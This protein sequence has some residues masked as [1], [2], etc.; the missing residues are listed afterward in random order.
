MIASVA[1]SYSLLF[2]CYLD[3]CGRRYFHKCH[4]FARIYGC[5]NRKT[6][7]PQIRFS[8]I[9]LR[10]EKSKSENEPVGQQKM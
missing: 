1:K 7:V 3:L 5:M 4:I 9:Y 8:V 6:P 2:L 10:L